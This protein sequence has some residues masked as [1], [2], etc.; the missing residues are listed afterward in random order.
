MVI[1]Y[2]RIS[3]GNINCYPIASVTATF[4]S[5]LE[6]SRLVPKELHHLP[7]IWAKNGDIQRYLI[8]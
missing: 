1:N 2:G 8:G 4:L 6:D 3:T 5:T 7:S